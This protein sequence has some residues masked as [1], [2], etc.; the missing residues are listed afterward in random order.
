MNPTLRLAH[1]D[2]YQAGRNG[3]KPKMIVVHLMAGTM[4]GTAA[5]FGNPAAGVSAHYGV[6]ASGEVH[7]Y[8]GEADTAWHAG[9]AQVNRWSIGIEHAGDHPASGDWKPSRLQFEASARLAAV[10]CRH[11]GIE[12]SEVTIVPHSAI[13]ER[14]PRCPGPGFD[15]AAYISLVRSYLDPEPVHQRVPVR[16]FDP[17][18]NEQ[19]GEGTFIT[20]TDKVYIKS[21][22]PVPPDF[23][24]GANVVKP[25]GA[26]APEEEAMKLRQ[27]IESI[28]SSGWLGK[29]VMSIIGIMLLVLLFFV[30]SGRAFA[31]TSPELLNPA[32]WFTSIE[33]VLIIAGVLAAYVTKLTTA[34]GKDW[35][36]TEGQ[37][38]VIL[39]AVIAALVGGIGGWLAI[40]TFAT[41]AGGFAGAVAAV[42]SALIAF[43]GSNASAKAD[44]QALAGAVNRIEALESERSKARL[45]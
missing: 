24:Y 17:V 26:A 22:G 30:L 43:L 7:Q 34:L 36:Q 18:R 2:N 6:S 28:W 20:E 40:G 9:D 19:I 10:I 44:R 29:A 4:E 11:H 33:A 23:A 35:F 37:S 38:T 27:T 25:I 8:V 15:L 16:L 42:F 14:K 45:L 3:A 31:Q 13:N 32:T 39:S 12:P 41:G 21:I 5:W 1:P